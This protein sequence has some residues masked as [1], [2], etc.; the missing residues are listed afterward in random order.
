MFCTH[1]FKKQETFGQL[2]WIWYGSKGASVHISFKI[3]QLLYSSKNAI[4]IWGEKTEHDQQLISLL[5]ENADL[6]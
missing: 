5:V 2:N 6:V 4:L 3:E 1:S